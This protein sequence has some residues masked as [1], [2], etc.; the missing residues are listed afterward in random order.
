MDII[1]VQ[2]NAPQD[3]SAHYFAS[4]PIFCI[5]RNFCG[6]NEAFIKRCKPRDRFLAIL[7]STIHWPSARNER[8]MK[9]DRCNIK[10][11]ETEIQNYDN[12]WQRRNIIVARVALQR[13]FLDARLAES[14]ESASKR[15]AS[16][17][18]NHLQRR[19]RK[20]LEMRLRSR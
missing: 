20:L 13:F 3:K 19:S 2:E 11:R 6:I 8:T 16:L 12:I 18:A 15:H 14:E 9:E 5:N 4:Y 17:R 7:P 1:V 10:S